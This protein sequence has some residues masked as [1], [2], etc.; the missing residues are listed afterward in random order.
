MHPKQL[1]RQ[2]NILFRPGNW[3]R[4]HSIKIVAKSQ[5]GCKGRPS[6]SYVNRSLTQQY[7]STQDA[8]PGFR[9]GEGGGEWMGG[10]LGSP[11]L[12][13]WHALG[14]SITL[15]AGDPKGPPHRPS[16]TL[17]PTEHPTPTHQVDA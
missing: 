5:G 11:A 10:P 7:A 3:P 12:L 13:G 16:S 6:I 1:A 15:R 14:G 2:N 8:G 9:R 4:W 17:A